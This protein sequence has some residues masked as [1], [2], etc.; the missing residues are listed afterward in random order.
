MTA[1]IIPTGVGE[2]ITQE[3]L[4]KLNVSQQMEQNKAE[5]ERLGRVEGLAARLGVDFNSGLTEGQVRALANVRV[6]LA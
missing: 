2:P 4:D 1:Q 3:A 6:V 5:L